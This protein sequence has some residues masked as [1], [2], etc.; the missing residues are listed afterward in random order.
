MVDHNRPLRFLLTGIIMKD[1]DL[2]KS[3]WGILIKSGGDNNES[4]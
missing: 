3:S 4:I 1:R 2:E